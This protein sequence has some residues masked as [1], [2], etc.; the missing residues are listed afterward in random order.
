MKRENLQDRV[1]DQL[2][3]IGDNPKFVGAFFKHPSV[4]YIFDL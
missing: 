4:A 3:K 2:Q 1:Q